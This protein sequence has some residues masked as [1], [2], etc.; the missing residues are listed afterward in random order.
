MRDRLQRLLARR[1]SALETVSREKDS[2]ASLEQKLADT[3]QAQQV[4]KDVAEAVQKEA[5]ERV[6]SIVTQCL[7]AV[8]GEDAYTFEI[9]FVQRRNKTEADLV[10]RRGDLVLSPLEE[11]GGGVCDIV[12]LALRIAALVLAQPRRRQ[13]LAL[14]EPL[15]HLSGNH[16]EAVAS[17]LEQLSEEL[18]IQMLLITHF[19]EFQVGRVIEL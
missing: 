2:V 10:L 9:R 19:T 18:G 5:H 6:A 15:K 4:V 11:A 8:F 12:A 13:F 14:D 1:Q 7:K 17:L 3:L 16:R